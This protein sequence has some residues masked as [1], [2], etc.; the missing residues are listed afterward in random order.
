MRPVHLASRKQIL[1]DKGPGVAK[2]WATAC[3]RVF[4]IDADVNV[5]Q[6]IRGVSCKQCQRS[7]WFA[8]VE[9]N[10]YAEEVGGLIG[11]RDD[12]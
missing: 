4:E 7:A 12:Y 11:R 5:T 9:A 3:R 8:E 6:D 10:W 2:F 1:T